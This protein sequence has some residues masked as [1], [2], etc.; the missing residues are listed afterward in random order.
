MCDK[1]DGRAVEAAAWSLCWG[2]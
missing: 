1:L 2:D